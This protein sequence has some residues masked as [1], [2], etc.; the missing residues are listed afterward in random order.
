MYFANAEVAAVAMATVGHLFLSVPSALVCSLIFISQQPLSAC[1]AWQF[2]LELLL[3]CSAQG[4]N[5]PAEFAT[6]LVVDKKT[7]KKS[8]KDILNTKFAIT[9]KRDWHFEAKSRI[10]S[11][12]TFIHQKPVEKR[13]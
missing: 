8:T 6:S 7:R 1:R 11:H 3:L 9:Y 12:T 10:T 5:A 4:R 2:L 13:Q